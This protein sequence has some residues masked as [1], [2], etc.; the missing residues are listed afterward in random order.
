LLDKA[1]KKLCVKEDLVLEGIVRLAPSVTREHGRP[2]GV[3]EHVH[4][5]VRVADATPF[6]GED[7]RI[8]GAE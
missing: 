6:C 5:K 8:D 3:A 7:H 2:E 4:L 1:P